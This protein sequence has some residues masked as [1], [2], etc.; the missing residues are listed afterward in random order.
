MEQA[1]RALKKLL[2]QDPRVK[3]VSFNYYGLKVIWNNHLRDIIHIN[4]KQFGKPIRAKK[5]HFLWT[6][7]DVRWIDD[8]YDNKTVPRH[9]RYNFNELET[10]DDEYFNLSRWSYENYSGLKFLDRYLFVH[11]LL[12]YI[13]EHGW[14][15]FKYPDEVLR[16]NYQ[17]IIDEGTNSHRKRIGYRLAKYLYKNKD[18]PGDLILENFMPSG[19]YNTS[20]VKLIFNFKHKYTICKWY[21]AIFKIIRKNRS[22]KKNGI[23]KVVDFDY[24]TMIKSI[25]VSKFRDK[26]FKSY[27]FRPVNLYRAIIYDLGLSGKTFFDFEPRYGEK[28]LAA[29]VEECPYYFRPTCPFDTYY[30]DVANFIENTNISKYDESIRYDFS[31]V[32]FDFK[33]N[34]SVFEHYMENYFKKVDTNI[35]FV[36][37]AYIDDISKKYPP[38]KKIPLIANSHY[39]VLNG[40]LFVYN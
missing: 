20:S 6:V 35:I 13:V 2:E 19:H 34:M 7:P 22:L 5:K 4:R 25:K 29:A 37:N 38:F 3:K 17:S 15:L 26:H 40:Y 12:D 18:R 32:D 16:E 21:K 9:F 23:N 31:I 27:S 30:K 39:A 36:S 8:I 1:Y 10:K 28:F 24:K 11:G 14:Q 33:F